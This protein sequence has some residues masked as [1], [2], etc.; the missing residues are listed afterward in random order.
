M[1]LLGN[2][3]Y[4]I[5]V[6][7][8]DNCIIGPQCYIGSN[9]ILG[10]NCYLREGVKIGSDTIIGDRF[11]AQPSAVVGADG[12]SFVTEKSSAVEEMRADLSKSTTNKMKAKFGIGYIPWR[13]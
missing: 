7:I 5:N 3:S 12:F 1:F 11:F 2:G 4:F 10:L 13:A 9:S 6:Q 8:G